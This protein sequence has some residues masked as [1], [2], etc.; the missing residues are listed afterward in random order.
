VIGLVAERTRTSATEVRAVLY[1]G[2]PADDAALVRLAQELPKLEIAVR[3]D[4]AGRS[5]GQ[6]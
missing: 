2:E 6:P 3:Q 4:D 1:G 5:G